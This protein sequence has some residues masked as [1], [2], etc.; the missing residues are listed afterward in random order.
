MKV[1]FLATAGGKIAAA[2]AAATVIIG[3]GIGVVLLQNQNDADN[4]NNEPEIVI[5][6]QDD[7]CAKVRYTNENYPDFSFEYNPCEWEIEEL[8]ASSGFDSINVA[9]VILSK[10]DSSLVFSIKPVARPDNMGYGFCYDEEYEIFKSYGSEYFENLGRVLIAEKWFYLNNIYS[11]DSNRKVSQLPENLS[12]PRKPGNS[13]CSGDLSIWT[14]SNVQFSN[15]DGL[16]GN[17]TGVIELSFKGSDVTKADEVVKSM[18]WT[19]EQ[20]AKSAEQKNNIGL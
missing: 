14:A 11:Y 8:S 19:P 7:S 15:I 16:S 4:T 10:D 20:F 2:L 12:G 17:F 9:E 6:Q 3:G 18:T 5:D 1:G 13:Y